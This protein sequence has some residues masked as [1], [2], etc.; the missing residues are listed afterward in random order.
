MYELK[1]SITTEV[2][3]GSVSSTIGIK[4]TGNQWRPLPEP[5]PV[6]VP[7]EVK[8]PELDVNWEKV[9]ETATVIGAGVAIIGIILIPFTSGASVVLVV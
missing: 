2:E 5:K 1:E 4:K 8:V 6:T 7:Y 9:G 3:G